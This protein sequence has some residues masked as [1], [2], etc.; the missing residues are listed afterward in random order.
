MA[1]G[2]TAPRDSIAELDEFPEDGNRYELLVQLF[3]FTQ[4]EP[5]VL[6]VP[7]RFPM[8]APWVEMTEHWLA[9]EVLSR[10]SRRYDRDFKRDAYLALGVKTVWL[11]EIADRCVDVC[12]IQ[13]AG[14]AMRESFDWHVRDPD[15]NV[16]IDMDVLFAGLR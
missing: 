1:M 4:L 2:I 12:D 9:V 3:P 14:R 10:S 5:D 7:S 6:V 11:V 13:G 16:R 8:D 15:V